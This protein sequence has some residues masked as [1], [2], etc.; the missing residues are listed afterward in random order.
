MPPFRRINLIASAVPAPVRPLATKPIKGA[1]IVHILD[2]CWIQ[3]EK[4]RR[5]REQSVRANGH[6]TIDS[7]VRA[8]IA[9]YINHACK[10]NANP[11]SPRKQGGDPRHQ[12]HRARRRDQLRL[13]YRYLPYQADRLRCATCEE[14]AA[15]S[16]PRRAEKLRLK[17]KAGRL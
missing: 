17:A 14:E 1:K 2:R 5:D 6:W 16:A 10:P 8:N 4:G 3:K 15:S 9:R 12:E 7:S 13:R 11:T